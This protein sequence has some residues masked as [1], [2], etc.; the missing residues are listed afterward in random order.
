MRRS[1]DITQHLENKTHEVKL[2]SGVVARDAR[3]VV[4]TA[5]STFI[6][7][8]IKNEASLLFSI[9]SFH[10]S[11]SSQGEQHNEK[12]I[13]L[14]LQK[15]FLGLAWSCDIELTAEEYPPELVDLKNEIH[16]QF[17]C[18]LYRA[19]SAFQHLID[20]VKHLIS[21]TDN[22]DRM[23]DCAQHLLSVLHKQLPT[24]NVL[25][26]LFLRFFVSSIAEVIG[27]LAH[28]IVKDSSTSSRD[29]LLSMES[30]LCHNRDLAL[31]YTRLAKM[32]LLWQHAAFSYI[33][34][35]IPSEAT[36]FKSFI[37]L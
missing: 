32:F 36:V 21:A 34:S 6:P 29:A 14:L 18:H 17:A 22:A 24:A 23:E 11:S 4:S 5:L 3:A 35:A 19:S 37:G 26:V 28:K 33:A 31:A 9:I 20:T 13:D 27:S 12:L 7:S 10:D 2:I 16:S 25:A 1:R 30:I 15:V 8:T